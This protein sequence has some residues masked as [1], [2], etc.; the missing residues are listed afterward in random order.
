M[1]KEEWVGEGMVCLNSKT[2]FGWGT[3]TKCSQKGLNKRNNKFQKEVWKHVLFD[4]GVQ[5]GTN[6]GFRM[7]NGQMVKY[8]QI[9]DGL[10]SFYPKR[11]VLEDKISTVPL[12]I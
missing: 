12:D 9:R 2:Y 10:T 5:S 7:I 8:S 3:D 11:R 6:K 1:F 4:D